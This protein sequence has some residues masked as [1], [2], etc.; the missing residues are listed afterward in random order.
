VMGRSTGTRKRPGGSQGQ[1]APGPTMRRTVNRAQVESG[2]SKGASKVVRRVMEKPF[3]IKMLR[4]APHRG[5]GLCAQRRDPSLSVQL[6]REAGLGLMG[7]NR[8]TSNRGWAARQEPSLVEGASKLSQAKKPKHPGI[9]G[10]LAFSA[11]GP[12]R[13]G[14]CPPGPFRQAHG[15]AVQAP[16][17]GSR[18]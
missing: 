5:G 4:M 7:L 12:R 17:R 10:A 16:G 2:R 6:R 9:F 8:T 13:S 11:A 3:A 1:A 15:G 14:V 18:K